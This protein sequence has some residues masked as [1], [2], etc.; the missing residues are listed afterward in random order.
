M[1][2]Y[3]R[4][5]KTSKLENVGFEMESQDIIIPEE[6]VSQAN[7]CSE[8]SSQGKRSRIWKYFKVTEC[9]NDGK[10]RLARCIICDEKGRKPS[11]CT[12]ACPNGGT[13]QLWKH[14][15]KEHKPV[16]VHYTHT[17]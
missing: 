15:T 14:C 4:L 6:S 16:S 12:F 9:T 7:T 17:H 3:N 11:K 2:L 5:V 10:S 8:V 13:T 1:A